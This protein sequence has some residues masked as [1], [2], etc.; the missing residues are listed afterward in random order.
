MTSEQQVIK[1]NPA[2]TFVSN[3]VCLKCDTCLEP[4]TMDEHLDPT[5]PVHCCET[6]H[7]R[8]PYVDANK[9]LRL[10]MVEAYLEMLEDDVR[11]IKKNVSLRQFFV[12][13]FKRYAQKT[14]TTENEE[15]EC[16]NK[17]GRGMWQ[18]HIIESFHPI[19]IKIIIKKIGRAFGAYQY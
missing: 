6:Y 8:I 17:M 11:R 5:H 12:S 16:I 10:A 18:H 13:E 4:H 19:I 9:P 14:F 15:Y 1:M 3:I 7:K 2:T